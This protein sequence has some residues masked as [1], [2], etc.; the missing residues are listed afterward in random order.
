MSATIINLSS[1]A[2]LRTLLAEKMVRQQYKGNKFARWFAPNYVSAGGANTAEE[3]VST[4]PD[5]PRWTSAPI[6]T[7]NA[8]IQQGRTDMVIPVRSVLTGMPKFGDAQLRGSE[9]PMAFTFREVKINRWRKA[10]APPVGM[11]RQKIKQWAKQDVMK[12]S[13]DLMLWYRNFLPSNILSAIHCGYSREVIAPVANHGLGQA[14]VSHPNM[15]VA[16]SGRVSYGSGRPGTS[17]YEASCEAAID[18]LSNTAEDKM[19]VAFIRNMV[20]EANRSNIRPLVTQS[21]YEFYPI[22][23]KDAAWIQLRNDPAFVAFAQSLTISEMAKS[24]LGN[25]AMCVIDQAVIYVDSMLWTAYTNADNGDVTAGT[26]EYGPRPSAAERAA[27]LFTGNTINAR[28]TGTN[29]CALLV[30]QS[31]L[32]IGTGEELDLIDEVEDYG[33]IKGMGIDMIKSIVRNET[34]DRL[35]LTGLTAGAFYENTSSLLGVTY[36]P[37]ALAYT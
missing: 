6:E 31:M 18:G 17:G 11:N 21:G 37:D 25:G 34:Y 33:A 24:P 7:V 8:F 14:I 28:D 36:S 5:G 15:I 3:V 29:A 10:V 27:G 4:G 20:F 26:V 9:E 1:D 13:N 23:L 35:G 30:G 2:A 12:A 22:W 32:S 19:S 16:G